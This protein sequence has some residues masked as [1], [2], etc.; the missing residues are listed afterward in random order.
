MSRIWA[1]WYIQIL[2]HLLNTSAKPWCVFSCQCVTHE[3]LWVVLFALR[4]RVL[5][6]TWKRKAPRPM[7][8]SCLA[9]TRPPCPAPLTVSYALLWHKLN[10]HTH[11]YIKHLYINISHWIFSF[12]PQ[13]HICTICAFTSIRHETWH[14][15]TKTAFLVGIYLLVR[16][17]IKWF[18]CQDCWWILI[19]FTDPYAHVSFL[20]L[21]K[22]TEKLQSTLNPTWDQTLIFNDVQIYGDPQNIAQ[23]PPDVIL[24][25]YD[26]D[27]VVSLSSYKWRVFA[28]LICSLIKYRW[29]NIQRKKKFL[30]LSSFSSICSIDSHLFRFF[31]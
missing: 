31:L 8:P 25:F 4:C 1:N 9:P 7:P 24:E 15:W 13:G 17:I 2:T 22:R 6:L 14:R 12:A 26:N 16:N 11:L 27:Q 30:E 23:Q 10:D 3:K 5:I 20:H 18:K 21:S 19:S 29:V 28:Q